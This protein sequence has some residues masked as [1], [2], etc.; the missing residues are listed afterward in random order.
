[1]VEADEPSADYPRAY[2]SYTNSRAPPEKHGTL[3]YFQARVRQASCMRTQSP[4]YCTTWDMNI[5]RDMASGQ[6]FVIEQGECTHYPREICEMTLAYDERDQTEGAY[7]QS[8]C[9]EER[10]P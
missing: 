9:L 6:R 8:D 4:P 3:T 10:K 7:S 5:L 1:M 2:I